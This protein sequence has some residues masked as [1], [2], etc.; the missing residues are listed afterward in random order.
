MD[1]NS[2]INRSNNKQIVIKHPNSPTDQYSKY[3]NSDSY[4]ENQQNLE[5]NPILHEKSIDDPINNF[6]MFVG[7]LLITTSEQ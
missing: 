3:L 6:I 2:K 5:N 7:G 1:T 4:G